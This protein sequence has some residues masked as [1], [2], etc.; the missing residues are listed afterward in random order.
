MTR[1]HAAP[2]MAT[3]FSVEGFL[4]DKRRYCSSISQTVGTA[5]ANVT[6]SDSIISKTDSPSIF[7]PGITSLLPAIG[8]ENASD[9]EL[10]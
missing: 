9:H 5:A 8:A 6:P 2:P 1:G 3:R 4:P 7:A 10:A